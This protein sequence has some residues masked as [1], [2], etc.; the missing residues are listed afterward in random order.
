[1]SSNQSPYAFEHFNHARVIVKGPYKAIQVIGEYTKTVVVR[2][3][4]C[5]QLISKPHKVPWIY[6]TIAR[7]VHF[8]ISYFGP[9]KT[10]DDNHPLIVLYNLLIQQ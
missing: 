7:E 3:P 4:D 9:N 2:R 10:F 6:L 1:M 8:G 5:V